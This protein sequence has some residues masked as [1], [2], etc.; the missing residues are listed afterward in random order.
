M[1]LINEQE[2]FGKWAS[3]VESNTG[4]TERSKVEWMSKY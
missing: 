2:I 3:I 4:I 1:Y